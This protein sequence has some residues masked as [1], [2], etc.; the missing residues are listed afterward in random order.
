MKKMSRAAYMEWSTPVSDAVAVML[1]TVGTS[2]A[3]IPGATKYVGG[4]IT[5]SGAVPWSAGDWALFPNARKVR[6][7]Q[8]PGQ[9]MALEAWDVIDLENGAFT[10]AEAVAETK[11]RVDAGITWTYIYAT[12]SNLAA[13]T[14][15]LKAEGTHYWNGHVMYWLADWNLNEAEAAALIG[16]FVE[17]ATCIGVQ[18]ASPT[19][20]PNTVVP[21]GSHTLAQANVDISVVDANWMPSSAPAPVTP[22]VPTAVTHHAEL[23]EDDG[24]GSFTAKPVSS[25]DDTHWQ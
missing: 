14:A 24:H 8:N 6:I 15:A 13:F 4:Y 3:N 9:G 18:W 7:Y 17:G 20:N 5:G 19:S 11:R 21:G 12:R 2:A 16:T 25:T 23:V 1:D 10:V 22:P